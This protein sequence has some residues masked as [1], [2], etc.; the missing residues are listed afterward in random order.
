MVCALA[1]VSCVILCFPRVNCLQ[2]QSV[3]I[4]VEDDPA[5]RLEM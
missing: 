3:W 2:E 4:A 1:S 5:D